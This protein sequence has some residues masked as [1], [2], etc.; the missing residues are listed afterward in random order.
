MRR[1]RRERVVV[2]TGASAGVG[3]ATARAFARQGA[4]IALLARGAAGLEGARREVEALGGTALVVPADVADPDQVEAAADRAERELGP[5]DVWVNNAM[6]SVFSPVREMTPEDYRRVTEVTYLGYVYCTLSALRRMLP[7][8]RGKI[9]FVGSALAYRGIPLQSAYCAAKHAV[10]GFFDSLRTELMHDGSKVQVT[11]VQL[12]A[13]NTPQFRWVKSRLPNKAQPVPPILQPEVAADAILFAADHDR[14][15]LWVG[16]PTVKA[17][18][19]NRI[20]PWY[21][22]LRLA[23]EGVQAQQ[24]DEPEDPDRPHNLWEPVD[25]EVDFGA[26]GDFDVRSRPST[27]Q[28]WLAKH[29]PALSVA[30]AAIAAAAAVL[31]GLATRNGRSGEPEADSAEA[32]DAQLAWLEERHPMPD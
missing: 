8:D 21:A 14:R 27:S 5:I 2:I 30:G 25:D 28:L 32:F 22:D 13:L 17:I 9:I 1:R 7:R 24:L 19:G 11:M 29:R 31:T 26:H 6:N 12:P 4:R 3:R 10:Q 15:E 16:W 23:R 20:V 18:A